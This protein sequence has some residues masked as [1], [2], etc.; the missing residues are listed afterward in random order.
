MIKRIKRAVVLTLALVMAVSPASTGFISA[1]S[2]GAWISL[3]DNLDDALNYPGSSVCFETDEEYPWQPTEVEGADAAVSG[4]RD[5]SSSTSS[6][7]ADVAMS[8]GENLYFEWKAS[9]EEVYDNGRFYVNDEEVAS[10]TGSSEW[11]TVCYP[12]TASGSYSFRW[13]YEKDNVVSEADDCLYVRNVYAGVPL[14]PTSVS[15]PETLS[16]Y[17]GR[18]K[19]LAYTVTPAYAAGA[20]VVWHSSDETVAAVDENGVVTG[21]GPGVAVITCTT[22]NGH[23]DS[24]TVTVTEAPPGAELYA[25]RKSSSEEGLNAPAWVRFASD[26]LPAAEEIFTTNPNDYRT[27]DSAA[28]FH[29]KVYGFWSDGTFFSCDLG[30]FPYEAEGSGNYWGANIG[31]GMAYNYANS[32]MYALSS[33]SW[34][35]TKLYTV[36]V[37]TGEMT[38]I[39]AL[40]GDASEASAFAITTEGVGYIIDDAGNLCTMDLETGAAELVGPTGL[41]IMNAVSMEYDHNTGIMYYSYTTYD[42]TEIYMIDLSTGEAEQAGGASTSLQILSGM[43]VVY[44]PEWPEYS[45]VF[46]DGHTNEVIETQLVEEGLSA[47]APVVPLH[48][49]YVFVGWDAD[50]SIITTDI[51]VTAIF[52]E[53]AWDE[54]DEYLNVPNGTLNFRSGAEYSW[55]HTELNGRTVG[56]SG[57]ALAP[58]SESSVFTTVN[59]DAG[60]MIVFEWRADSAEYYGADYLK[61]YVNGVETA[62]VCGYTDFAEV[63]YDVPEDGTYILA[64]TYVKDGFTDAGADCGYLDNV[65]AGPMPQLDEIVMTPQASVPL[66]STGH[67]PFELFP[68]YSEAALG[69]S[70]DNT[71]AVE[72]D[73]ISGEFAAVGIGTATVTLAADNGVSASCTLVVVPAPAS[74]EAYAF[75]TYSQANYSFSGSWLGFASDGA[76]NLQQ[77]AAEVGDVYAAEQVCGVIYAFDSSG[78]FFTANVDDFT[79]QN[80]SEP[81]GAYVYDMAFDYSTHTMYAIASIGG[82]RTLAVVDLTTGQCTPVSGSSFEAEGS[83]IV[84]LAVSLE[85]EA[86]GIN[87][88]GDLYSVDTETAELTL[89]GATGYS[90]RYIQTMAFDHNTG[91]L[92][93][94]Q[95]SD[96]GGHFLVVDTESGLATDVAPGFGYYELVGLFFNYEYVPTA[97]DVNGDGLVN[98]DD[99]IIALR[100]ALGLVDLDPIRRLAADMDGDGIVDTTDAADILAAAMWG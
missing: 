86:Y 83:P 77:L 93:W 63:R 25:F 72:I 53:D 43:F 27:V 36:D 1:E 96:D 29:T 35:G 37:Y 2:P 68:M 64:W 16:V 79:P 4:N 45:V 69:W 38:P 14:D 84:C 52:E 59:L 48:E 90:V 15:I 62:S 95:Y 13:S 55:L 56:M 98:I 41:Q 44:E 57:N 66:G 9:C 20:H 89:V 17:A 75:C 34:S 5:V 42:T 6:V 18:V 71:D 31:A 12:V 76:Q 11:E 22:D 21:N 81:I 97:G 32:T 99:A 28:Y 26:D 78:R 73:P 19:Q 23:E 54:L 49:G 65:Y 47:Q 87:G 40:N 82:V 85:G 94:A 88:M 24:C 3:A 10:I 46:V 74:T 80:M 58:S 67:I 30:E 50:F 51:T 70:C 61:F 39:C 100:A 33:S 92:Y 60:D 8:A 7:Y 91:V